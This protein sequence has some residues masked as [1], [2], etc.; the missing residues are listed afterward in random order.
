MAQKFFQW[1]KKIFLKKKKFWPK[2]SHGTLIFLLLAFVDVLYMQLKFHAD[3]LCTFC[4]M[5]D[6]SLEATLSCQADTLLGLES[7]KIVQT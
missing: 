4:T 2:N 6:Q 1:E 3:T 7:A 5:L